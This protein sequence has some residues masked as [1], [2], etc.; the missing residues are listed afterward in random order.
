MPEKIAGNR[1]LFFL[2]RIF[3]VLVF[4]EGLVVVAIGIFLWVTMKNADAFVIVFLIL[5]PVECLMSIIGGSGKRSS[6]RLT[7]YLWIMTLIFLC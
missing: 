3:N 5:G 6:G 4:L 7:F 2:F 1:C